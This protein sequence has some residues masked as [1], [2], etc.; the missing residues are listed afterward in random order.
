[1][2]FA[3]WSFLIC[4]VLDNLDLVTR[5]ASFKYYIDFSLV[6]IFKK[7]NLILFFD[8]RLLGFKL[9]NFLYF[10]LCEVISTLYPGSR[11]SQVN[12]SIWF[13]TLIFLFSFFFHYLVFLRVNLHHLVSQ[14][15]NRTVLRIEMMRRCNKI[16]TNIY[17]KIEISIRLKRSLQCFL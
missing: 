10:S 16:T 12:F 9:H 13:F 14:L 7:K 5:I 15:I 2:N 6:F 1:M 3:S 11:I 17:K 4:L 8:I